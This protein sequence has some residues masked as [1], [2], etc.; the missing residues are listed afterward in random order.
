ML[1][2]HLRDYQTLI[3]YCLGILMLTPVLALA[4]GVRVIQNPSFDLTSTAGSVT[5]PPPG[6]LLG[7][8]A[9][10]AYW[11]DSS[12]VGGSSFQCIG[13]W[14]TTD[15]NNGASASARYIEVAL[16]ST[17]GAFGAQ[18]N[19]IVAELNATMQSRLYQPICLQAGETVTMNYYFSPRN[20]GVNQQVA[21][22]LWP[23]NDPGPIGNAI[24]AQNSIISSTVGFV[25]QTAVSQRPAPGCTRLVWKRSCRHQAVTAT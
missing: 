6:G 18:N 9:T 14:K 25:P 10:W 5:F 7:G 4:G 3:R 2:H 21:A 24:S 12:C 23:I 1:T 8:G 16:A 15:S 19:R 13:G 11:L 22:G 20:T 17:Y